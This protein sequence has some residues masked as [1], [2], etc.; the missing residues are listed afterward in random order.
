LQTAAHKQKLN[1]HR[2]LVK[3][4]RCRAWRRDPQL[5]ASGFACAGIERGSAISRGAPPSTLPTGLV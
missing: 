4:F 3:L 5:G 1:T 2:G